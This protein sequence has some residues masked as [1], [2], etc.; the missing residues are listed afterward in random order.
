VVVP[1]VDAL[2]AAIAQGLKAAYGKAPA[3][4]IPR[5]VRPRKKYGTVRGF[6]VVDPG[7]NW[8][9]I[10]RA[11]DTEEAAAQEQTSGLARIIDVAARLGDAR[12]DDEQALKTLE[13]GMAR[14]A[15]A[16]DLDRVRAQLYRVELLWRLERRDDAHTALQE[17][18]TIPLDEHDQAQIQHEMN[19]A[20]ELVRD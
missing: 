8:L 15:D 9:R 3:S 13:Q 2:Y 4:G 5:L 16:I 18:K 6:S 11:G 19:H 12:G 7:G 10:Y 20:D 17:A 1:N 14:H